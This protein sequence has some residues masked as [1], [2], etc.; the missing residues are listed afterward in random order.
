MLTSSFFYCQSHCQTLELHLERLQALHTNVLC[1][2]IASPLHHADSFSGE[3]K[4]MQYT[5]IWKDAAYNFIRNTF[6]YS[7]IKHIEKGKA[8]VQK[9][10][11]KQN[12]TLL[13]PIFI[14]YDKIPQARNSNLSEY[15]ILLILAMY[16]TL[17]SVY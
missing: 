12:K 5:V 15:H 1:K 10:K 17:F 14:L 16:L 11:K 9:L 6:K 3:Q 13:Y 8:Q 2:Q 4:L 7:N